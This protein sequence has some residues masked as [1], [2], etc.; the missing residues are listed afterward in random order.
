VRA[1]AKLDGTIPLL[2]KHQYAEIVV[3]ARELRKLEKE[4]DAV[5]REAVSAL[6][7]DG[8][9]G[10]YRDGA[11]DARV[12]IREKTV[13]ED[14]ENALDACDSIADTLLNLAVK[15]G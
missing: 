11:A 3:C 14:L 8:P 2:R 7:R 9:G 10:A 6:F 5:Y 15:H 4:A 1:T 13:L 12:L